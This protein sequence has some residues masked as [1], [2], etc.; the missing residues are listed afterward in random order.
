MSTSTLAALNGNATQSKAAHWLQATVKEFFSQVNWSDQPPEIQAIQMTTLEG[1]TPELSLQ[2]TVSQFFNA[3]P[4]DGKVVA[5]PATAEVPI[6][7][8]APPSGS[9]E[10]SVDDFADFF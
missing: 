3:I 7:D 8:D 6:S 1:S 10:I 5:A 4:W 9:G 2:L